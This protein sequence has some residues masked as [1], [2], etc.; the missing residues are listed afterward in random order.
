[1]NKKFKD[2][3]GQTIGRL[4]ILSVLRIAT[5]GGSFNAQCICGNFRTVAYSEL[6]NKRTLSCGC[7]QKETKIKNVTECAKRRIGQRRKTKNTKGIT[8]F[9]HV[10][11]NYK[12]NAV[13]RNR[14]FLLTQEDFR[15]LTSKNCTY[16]GQVPSNISLKIGKHIE[17]I[18]HNQYIYNGL[19]RVN[20]ELGYVI[21]NVVTCCKQCNVAKHD[22]THLN[23]LTY[24]NRLT[25]YQKGNI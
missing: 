17:T 13:K 21:S 14:E 18:M 15:E 4:K 8:G 5:N 10:Y 20:N 1:M 6:I 16:C 23:F 9:L 25:N 11:N 7:L 22:M 19:D 2:L 3:T 24:I 12:S